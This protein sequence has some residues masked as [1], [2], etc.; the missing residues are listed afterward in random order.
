MH[1]TAKQLYIDELEELDTELYNSDQRFKELLS[2]SADKII[3]TAFSMH[4][5]NAR[6]LIRAAIQ[7]FKKIQHSEAINKSE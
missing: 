4:I 3:I 1:T 7:H 6:M 5:E 2:N